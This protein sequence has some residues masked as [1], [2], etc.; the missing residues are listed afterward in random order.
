VPRK[1][2]K[3]PTRVSR[4][5]TESNRTPTERGSKESFFKKIEVIVGE[6]VNWDEPIERVAFEV[7]YPDSNGDVVWRSSAQYLD[8]GDID[9]DEKCLRLEHRL[10][11]RTN[12]KNGKAGERPIVITP[13]LVEALNDYVAGPRKEVTNEYGCEPLFT[14]LGG[15]LARTSL[16]RLVYNV[17][18]P[19][20]R[21]ELCP[22]CE[23]CPEAKCPE[24]V[25]PH[26]IRR[27]SIR[28]T[29]RKTCQSKS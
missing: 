12:L 14:S 3:R 27:G 11:Q 23:E 18:S 19:C 26:A 2:N 9:V 5:P 21:S 10:D 20:F 24:A 28:T 25:S 6:N 22:G 8:V 13:E 17:T 1:A 15:R 7:G 4:N 16:R 29:C